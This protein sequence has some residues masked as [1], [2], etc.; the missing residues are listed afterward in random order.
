MRIKGIVRTGTLE[1]NPPGS[2]RIEMTLKVQGV[3]AGQPRTLVIPYDL[4]LGDDTLDPDQIAG[5]GFE[6]DAE[7][8][9]WT[10]GGFVDRTRHRAGAQAAR[11]VSRAE[12]AREKVKRLALAT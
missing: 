8:E 12:I 11:R 9:R 2:D 4:L 5:K 1:E 7:E 3:G 6:A 10:L